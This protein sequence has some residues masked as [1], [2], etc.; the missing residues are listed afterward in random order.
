M[1]TKLKNM[2]LQS[3]TNSQPKCILIKNSQDTFFWKLQAPV[4]LNVNTVLESKSPNIW[5]SYCSKWLST[6]L[7]HMELEVSH[8]ISSENRSSTLEYLTLLITSSG[9]ISGILFSSQPME[10]C[11]DRKS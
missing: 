5:T 6:K 9:K 11:S 3:S 4:T 10:L 2:P 7:R 1:L 8:S